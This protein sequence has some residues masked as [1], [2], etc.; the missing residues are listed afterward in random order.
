MSAEMLRALST[1][2]LKTFT[3]AWCVC[4]CVSVCLS[5]CLS[6]SYTHLTM[7]YSLHP[8]L[9]QEA[10]APARPPL[11]S[12]LIGG[13]GSLLA[14]DTVVIKEKGSNLRQET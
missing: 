4:V 12:S 13:G 6:L 11:C 9:S 8:L 2:T 10:R 3:G 14:I 1:G 7:L 5:L